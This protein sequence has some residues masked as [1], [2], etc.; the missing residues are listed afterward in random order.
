MIKKAYKYRLYPNKEQEVLLSKH[1][2]C[3]RYVYNWGLSKKIEAYEKD[4]KS[5]SCFDL[6]NMLVEVKRKEETEW[7][8]EVNS[9]SLQMSLRNLDNAFVRF[10]REKK[11][12]PK[13]K[14]K[15]DGKQSFQVPQHGS[16]DWEKGK[17]FIPKFSPISVVLHRKFEGKIK[18]MTVKKMPTGKYFV[19]V[20]V[21][22]EGELPK[23]PKI[24]EETTVGIDLGL[25][26]FITKSTG[27]KI[28][29]PKPLKNN[30]ERMRVLQ[31][32]LSRKQKGSSNRKKAR[33]KVAL[34]HERIANIR[35]DYTHKESYKL[36]HEKQVQSIAIEN[37]GIADMMKKSYLAR[38]I[39][40]V[41]WGEFVRQ[42]EYK[43][44]W[45]GKNLLVI[46]RFELST[47]TCSSCGEV[48]RELTIVDR[49]WVCR[50]G[51]KHD[52]D[53][54]AAINVKKF[55]L[56]GE[57]LK[58]RVGTTRRACGVAADRRNEEAGSC[59]L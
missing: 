24:S 52:R 59:R 49:E 9:Q 23:K 29:H 38:G 54:N 2:G 14:S 11:G 3:A 5:I 13:F 47:K 17:L 32:R 30:L 10:F 16:I 45:Y 26:S 12:F 27:E 41:S 58:H 8:K 19:T 18:T 51:V 37:L 39:S 21:E 57:N 6:T 31:R 28:E 50:C 56:R 1:F 55:A 40:D 33:L 22:T 46:G 43:T 25:M 42:L 36:T 20:L 34:C 15:K 53:I 35:K 48:N 44:E 4:K 7:L